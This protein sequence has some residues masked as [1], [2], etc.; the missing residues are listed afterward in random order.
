[1]SPI[2]EEL[3]D[4][5]DRDALAAEGGARLRRAVT[6]TVALMADLN[7]LILCDFD[8]LVTDLLNR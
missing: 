8:V 7:M 5:V 6:I 4:N 2:K 3:N 1:M